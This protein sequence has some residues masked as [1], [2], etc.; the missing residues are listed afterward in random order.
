[1]SK[2]MMLPVISSNIRE[3]GHTA[4]DG[5]KGELYLRF[6][7]G[8]LFS[9]TDVPEDVYQQLRIADSVGKFYHSEIRGKFEGKPVPEE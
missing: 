5:E 1:M 9:Y 7:N 2:P 4:I 6:N 3:I 8:S